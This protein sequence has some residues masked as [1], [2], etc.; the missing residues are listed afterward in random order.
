VR[1]AATAPLQ[2][3]PYEPNRL[4][5]RS[6]LALGVWF[7]DQL[8]AAAAEPPEALFQFKV[9]AFTDA[10]KDAAAPAERTRARRARIDE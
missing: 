3:T 4:K 9:W 8:A 1:E 7:G 2:V 6:V 10:A 5:T